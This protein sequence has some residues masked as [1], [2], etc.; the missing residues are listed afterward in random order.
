M[1]PAGINGTL[2]AMI[3]ITFVHNYLLYIFFQYYYASQ[4]LII[5]EEIFKSITPLNRNDFL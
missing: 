5:Y 4:Q 1:I 3:F 2:N